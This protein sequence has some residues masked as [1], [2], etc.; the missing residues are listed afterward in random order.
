MLTVRAVLGARSRLSRT[1][2]DN[3][4]LR[5]LA[6]LDVKNYFCPLILSCLYTSR[7]VALHSISDLEQPTPMHTNGNWVV[8]GSTPSLTQDPM[9]IHQGALGSKTKKLTVVRRGS[10]FHR[11]K[12]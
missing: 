11:P 10:F 1:D 2:C 3:K 8:Q 12:H 7:E 4:T 9:I 5:S 6:P